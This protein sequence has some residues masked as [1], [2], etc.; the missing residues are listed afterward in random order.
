MK[1][2]FEKKTVSDLKKR[3]LDDRGKRVFW[4]VELKIER[5]LAERVT[6]DTAGNIA[7]TPHDLIDWD[8]S[9]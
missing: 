6:P 4:F 7:W 3:M 5:A 1:E 8:R 9:A 2:F